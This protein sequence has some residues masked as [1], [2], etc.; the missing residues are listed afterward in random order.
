M[1]LRFV[2]MWSRATEY[3]T[4]RQPGGVRNDSVLYVLTKSGAPSAS[5]P[6]RSTM[7]WYSMDPPSM[8]R[9]PASIHLSSSRQMMRSMKPLSSSSCLRRTVSVPPCGSTI[10]STRAVP[11]SSLLPACAGGAVVH[12]R[13][14]TKRCSIS[15]SGS[16][17]VAC[18]TPFDTIDCQPAVLLYTIDVALSSGILLKIMFPVLETAPIGSDTTLKPFVLALAMKL[19]WWL[20]QEHP[21]ISLSRIMS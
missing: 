20:L 14:V 17:V 3:S 10:L 18:R 15:P 12:C 5:L 19:L 16:V 4:P 2:I 6:S 7:S 9:S 21:H 1:C 13:C 8:L 11:A